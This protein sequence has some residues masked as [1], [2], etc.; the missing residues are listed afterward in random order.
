VQRWRTVTAVPLLTALVVTV[1]ALVV[2]PT[3]TSTTT[4]VPEVKNQ[5]RLP[6]AVAGL[7]GQLGLNPLG[8]PTQSPRFYASVVLSRELL[9]QALL[10]QYADPRS[11]N[12]GADSASFLR[13][14]GIKGRDR[15]DSLALGVRKAKALIDVSVDNATNIVSLSVEGRYP[16]LTAAVA[17]RLVTFLNDFNTEHRQSQARERRKF[18]E[19]RVTDAER[20]LRQDEGAVK[21][22]YEHNRGWQEAPQLVYEEA[23]LRRGVDISREVYLTLKREYE[24]ARIEEVNDTPV[25]TVIDLAIPPRERSQPRRAL[26]VFSALVLGAIVGAGWAVGAGYMER[27]RREKELEFREFRSLLERTRGEIGQAVRRL[28][29]RTD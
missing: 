18:V 2:P 10:S 20:Q 8:D 22:F 28:V 15:E 11:A 29:R 6:S 3:Y 17:N 12:P 19:G 27:A 13:I 24:T 16:T 9:E 23:R 25:I 4:F 14:L 7:A 26:W 21:D 1:V 5:T